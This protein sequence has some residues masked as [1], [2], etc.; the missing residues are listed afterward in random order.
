[1]DLRALLLCLKEGFCLLVGSVEYCS[2]VLLK[3]LNCEAKSN[4]LVKKWKEQQRRE[5]KRESGHAGSAVEID[6]GG[7]SGASK[8]EGEKADEEWSC[9][10]DAHVQERRE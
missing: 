10:R 5:Q 6:Y 2:S 8:S 3:W 7:S 4:S 1:M 9:K